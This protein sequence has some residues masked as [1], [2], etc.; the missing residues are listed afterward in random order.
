MAKSDE[1]TL[2]SLII[3]LSKVPSTRLQPIPLPCNRQQRGECQ[4]I[5]LGANVSFVTLYVLLR[6]HGIYCLRLG[7]LVTFRQ[8]SILS[9]TRIPVSLPSS[10][11]E[12]RFRP[13]HNWRP[14]SMSGYVWFDFGPNESD[15]SLGSC[16][17]DRSGCL[18]SL[19]LFLQAQV[20]TRR[21]VIYSKICSTWDILI[22]RYFSSFVVQPTVLL[23]GPFT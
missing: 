3:L 11:T 2:K 12:R 8:T 4:R 10:A 20:Y 16:E 6:Y 22:G 21:G 15:G 19:F 23:L 18:Q 13:S 5:A 7:S 17:V 9:V 1:D 14:R